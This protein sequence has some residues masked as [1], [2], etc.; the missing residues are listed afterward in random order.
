MRHVDFLLRVLLQLVILYSMKDLCK[1]IKVPP[2]EP[3][4]GYL[5]VRVD[6]RK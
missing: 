4:A 2:L 6:D 3:A 1:K 5:R